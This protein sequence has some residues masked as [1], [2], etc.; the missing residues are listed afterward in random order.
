MI[1]T[2][3]HERTNGFGIEFEFSLDV[4]FGVATE[5]IRP[6]FGLNEA[7]VIAGVGE[8]RVVEFQLARGFVDDDSRSRVE[9]DE[10]TVF[11]PLDFGRW[12][13]AALNLALEDSVG[14]LVDGDR[15]ARLR[16]EMRLGDDLQLDGGA[17]LTGQV[18]SD[19]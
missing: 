10:S 11:V 3:F 15:G 19:A 9:V 14:L 4:K 17:T 8:S 13:R 12:V 2:Q 18:G 16:D 5:F 6:T 1:A 7:R